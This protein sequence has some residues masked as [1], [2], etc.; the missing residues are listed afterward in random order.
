MIV[1]FLIVAIVIQS[2]MYYIERKDLYSR[3]MAKDLQ[4]YKSESRSRTIPNQIRKKLN[5]QKGGS[6]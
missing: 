1:Y 2:I 6:G 5:E 3:I 4:E